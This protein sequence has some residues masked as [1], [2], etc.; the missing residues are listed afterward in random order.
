[1]KD[2]NREI[3]R[4]IIFLLIVS[5]V[6]IFTLF[7][8]AGKVQADELYVSS[9]HFIYDGGITSNDPEQQIKDHICISLLVFL[10]ARGESPVTQLHHGMVAINRVLDKSRWPNTIC[11]VLKQKGQFESV[12]YKEVKVINELMSGNLDAIDKYIVDNYSDSI[13]NIRSWQAINVLTFG[14]IAIDELTE[15]WV[16]ADHFLVPEIITERGRKIPMWYHKKDLV[17][18]SGTTHFLQTRR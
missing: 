13:I 15:E 5:L 1:M 7:T 11:G 16:K 12:K 17:T 3:V 4:G 9:P 6:S 14:L 2:I 8:V 10:E 18:I